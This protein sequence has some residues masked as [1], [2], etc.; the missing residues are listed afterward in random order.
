MIALPCN[1][2][3]GVLGLALCLAP[4][5]HLSPE[6][7][8]GLAGMPSE[9]HLAVP[10]E[11]F[12]L[13]GQALFHRFRLERPAQRDDVR[14]AEG[15]PQRGSQFFDA[16]V[17][18]LLTQDRPADPLHG[19]ALQGMLLAPADLCQ[20]VALGLLLGRDGPL[21]HVIRTS[22]GTCAASH[23]IRRAGA[24]HGAHPCRSQGP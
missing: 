4:L 17:A 2:F 16:L 20:P 19:V 5:P 1:P 10:F 24:G 11:I 22:R 18:P 3:S 8:G 21:L 15:R 9:P 23:A 14:P 6:I 12:A 7:L 13:T